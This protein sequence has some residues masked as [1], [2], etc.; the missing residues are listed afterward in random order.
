[1]GCFTLVLTP[2]IMCSRGIITADIR[3]ARDCCF[4]DKFPE[5]SVVPWQWHDT[6]SGTG[7]ESKN[8]LKMEMCLDS[9]SR[10]CQAQ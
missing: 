10:S 7:S 6:F 8:N 4:Q 1:M 2:V 9:K 3:F 5:T